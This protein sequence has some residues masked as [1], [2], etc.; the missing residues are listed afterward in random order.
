MLENCKF[1]LSLDIGGANTKSSFMCLDMGSYVQNSEPKH[2][3]RYKNILKLSHSLF[4]STLYFP[5]W[6]RNQ[7]QF[8]KILIS[9]RAKS[10]KFLLE[11]I[12]VQYPEITS[13]K[14][15]NSGF[16]YQKEGKQFKKMRDQIKEACP[17]EYNVV[18]TI[19]A[20]LS[21]A[22]STKKEGITLICKQLQEVFNP[23][24]LHLI[25]VNAEFISIKEALSDYLSVSAS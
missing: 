3:E 9:L 24:Y 2:I 7:S 13:V 18:I 17:I 23:N 22:F 21:D 10:E 5:F 1:V 14:L 19:T 8:K 12:M 11:H 4:Y 15:N 20:E 6:E 25:N 16:C